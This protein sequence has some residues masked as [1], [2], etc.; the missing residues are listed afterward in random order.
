MGDFQRNNVK[1]VEMCSVGGEMAKLVNF[2][3]G[4]VIVEN[5]LW[6]IKS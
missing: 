2:F 3:L 6:F 1:G 5:S 4:L